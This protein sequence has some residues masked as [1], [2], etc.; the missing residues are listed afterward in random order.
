MSRVLKIV[1]VVAIIVLIINDGGRLGQAVVHLRTATGQVLDSTTQSTSGAPQQRVIDVLSAQASTNHIHITRS[2]VDDDLIHIW[3]E[4]RVSGTWV[5]GPV[6]A[7]QQG[8]PFAKAWGVPI[9]IYY[10]ESAA[11]S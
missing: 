8:V 4:E 6:I 3:T 2:S 1:V 7:L 10:D 9:A 5:I 11:R